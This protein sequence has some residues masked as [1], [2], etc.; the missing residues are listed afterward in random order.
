MSKRV[1]QKT[2]KRVE[3]KY[4]VPKSVVATLLADLDQHVEA[5]DFATSTI[6]SLYFDTADF[7]MIQDS[8][9]KK[10][11]KEKIRLRTYFEDPDGNTPV[12][13]ELKQKMAGVG[14]KYRVATTQ[15]KALFNLVGASTSDANL[16]V[17]LRTLEQR[18]GRIAPQML[19]RYQRQSFKGR[20]EQA[21]RLTLDSEITYCLSQQLGVTSHAP[22]PLLPANH[23]ILEIKVNGEQPGWLVELLEKH[24]LEK[25]SFSKYG[26]AY[27]LHQEMTG[28]VAYA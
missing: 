9:A 7:A 19:I 23:L 15:N 8:L 2:F 22:Q 25:V 21:V 20:Q 6:S 13:L 14:Y 18:Y 28:E 12:F 26:R 3:T 10:H 17:Q 5:D 4:L 27:Q 1:Y 16:A 11:G 24:G